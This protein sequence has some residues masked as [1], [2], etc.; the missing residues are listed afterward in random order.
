MLE[1]R[2]IRVRPGLA[3]DARKVVTLVLGNLRGGVPPGFDDIAEIKMS[4]GMA[5]SVADD[6]LKVGA[7][8]EGASDEPT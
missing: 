1:C 5:R 2:A 6:L 4:P 3:E 8:I 7:E